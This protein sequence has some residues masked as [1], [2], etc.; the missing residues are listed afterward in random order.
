MVSAGPVVRRCSEGQEAKNGK[1][2][3]PNLLLRLTK[4]IIDKTATRNKRT[5]SNQQYLH[6]DLD[7][8]VKRMQDFRY[9]RCKTTYPVQ[10]S[11]TRYA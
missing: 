4:L 5:R 9:G 2:A 1:G 3:T 8:M 6:V 10:R 11:D 7:V